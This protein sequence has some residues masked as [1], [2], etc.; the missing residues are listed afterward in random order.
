MDGLK[1]SLG[2][3]SFMEKQPSFATVYLSE[4]GFVNQPTSVSTNWKGRVLASY[5]V[6]DDGVAHDAALLEDTYRTEA[7]GWAAEGDNGAAHYAIV[8]GFTE[9]ADLLSRAGMQG[10]VVEFVPLTSGESEESI[11]RDL[12]LHEEAILQGKASPMPVGEVGDTESATF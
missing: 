8:R 2:Y 1:R 9:Q 6:P 5:L 10:R 7:N 4:K 11:M 3:M 12:K